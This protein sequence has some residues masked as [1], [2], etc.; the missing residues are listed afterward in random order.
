MKRR[1]DGRWQKSITIGGK[2][3]FFYSYAET[4]KKAERDILQQMLAYSEEEEA[5]RLLEDVSDEWYDFHTSHLEYSSATRYKCYVKQLNEYF[6]K[7][8]IKDI[9]TNDVEEMLLDMVSKDYSSKTIKDFLSVTKMIFKYSHKR[10]YIDEDVTLYISPPLGKAPVT[11]KP[12]DETDSINLSKAL[13]CTFGLLAFFYLCTGLRKSEALALQWK[14]IDFDNNIIKVYKKVYYVS[15][16]PYIKECTKTKAGTR[17]VILLDVLA[18]QLLPLKGKPDEYIFN[19]DGKLLDKSYYTRQWE[20]FK[21]ESNIDITAHPLRH[22]Y[23]TIVFEAGVP[24]KDAQSLM[25][26]SSIVV[27]HNIYTHIRA[28][29]MK[30][31]A[32]RL[33]SYMKKSLNPDLDTQNND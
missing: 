30:E 14:D 1:P 11:R 26:H 18:E 3:K 32:N 20:K 21:K 24:E 4:E 9:T 19:R 29:R 6:P 33:N 10:K 22:T 5:G 2:R 23:S 16:K 27:T 25:G 28:G 13:D 12:L 8:Y 7:A 15:N 17:S 31:T